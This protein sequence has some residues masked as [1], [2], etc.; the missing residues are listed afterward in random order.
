[1]KHTCKNGCEVT[2][3]EPNTEHEAIFEMLVRLS[4]ESDY[5]PFSSEDF[6]IGSEQL[7]NYIDYLNR[8]ENSIFLAAAV[9]TSDSEHAIVGFA[10][11]EGGRRIRTHHCANLGIGILQAYHR[12]GIGSA[13]MTELIRYALESE[14]IAKIEL[15]TGK[16]NHAAIALYKKHDFYVEGVSKRALYINDRFYDYVHM[17]R[18]ID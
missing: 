18:L 12:L 17:G 13:L 10:Y 2:I 4:D 16:E 15:Q 7:K 5:L 8:A 1:M 3:F 11:L 6:G 14:S 9:K